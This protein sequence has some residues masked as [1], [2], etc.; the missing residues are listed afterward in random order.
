MRRAWRE[1][2]VFQQLTGAVQRQHPAGIPRQ[3]ELSLSIEGKTGGMRW[4]PPRLH[5]HA[6]RAAHLPPDAQLHIVQAD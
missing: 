4:T 1:Q 5:L 6:L 2:P 3:E